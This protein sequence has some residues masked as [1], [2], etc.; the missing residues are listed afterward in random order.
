MMGGCLCGA[1]RYQVTTEP[2]VSANCHCSMCRRHSGAAFLT[3]FAVPRSAF[4]M[5]QGEPAAYRSSADAVR[6]HCGTCG[7]PLTFVFD[8]DPGSVWVTVGTLDDPSA[9]RPSENWF[10][11]DKVTWVTL[12]QHLKAWSAAPEG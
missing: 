10:V 6:T 8:A 5:Q 3:Y 11:R 1:C 12:D 7:S 2:R 4:V 9:V